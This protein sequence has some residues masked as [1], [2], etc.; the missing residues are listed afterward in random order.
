[1]WERV[2]QGARRWLLQSPALQERV[3]KNAAETYNW[4]PE[5]YKKF[6]LGE[7]ERYREVV[8]LSGAKQVD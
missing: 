5:E 3:A 8:R 6:V 4:S 1:M 2:R 7:I